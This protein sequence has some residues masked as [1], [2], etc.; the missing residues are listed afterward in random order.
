MTG[1][2]IHYSEPVEF[3]KAMPGAK[4]IVIWKRN[5]DFTPAVARTAKPKNPTKPKSRLARNVAIDDEIG[6]AADANKGTTMTDIN[7]GPYYAM[8]D[9][10]ALARQAQTGETYQKAFTECYCDPRN[11][12]IRDGAQYDH[13]SKS[14]DAMYG[15][16]LSL[17]PVA[18]AAA[19]YDPLAKAAEMAEHLGPAHAK[20]HSLAVDHQRAHGG[21]SYAQAYSHL[22]SRPENVSLRNAVK[23]EHM[24]STMAGLGEGLG[25]AAPAD[26]LQDYVSPGSARG[27]LEQ[28]VI[29]RMK[30]N[31]KLSYQQSFTQEYLD[32]KNRSLKERY[33]SESILRAQAREPAPAFP[34]YT[35]PGHR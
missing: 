25:K 12:A 32:P 30:N 14:H 17:I 28:L 9:R 19:S 15:T 5:D 10:Q 18:K 35:A 11:A 26:A 2:F 3:H 22:Y 1:H 33:D 4:S 31:P 34:R 24:R 20:L 8:L 21:M 23:A 7:R 6:E 16:R 29:T 13:L 27:E